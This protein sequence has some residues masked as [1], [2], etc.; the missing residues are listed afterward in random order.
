M[1]GEV[2][3]FTFQAEINQLMSLIINTFYSNKEV[4][5]RELISN[6]SD[7]LDKIRYQSLSDVSVLDSKRELEI[8]IIPNKEAKTLTII[9]SGVGMTKA[10]L[11]KNLGT[12]ANSGTKSFMEQ[13]QSGAAD[14][15]MI[16][17]FGVGFYSAYLVADTVIVHS[18]NNDDEQYVWESSAGGEFT[19]ALD[20]T[21]PLGRGTK[22]V[23]H[24]KEDQ[25]DYLDEQKI[26]NLVKKHSEFIQYPIS[27][28][29][30]KEVEKEVEEPKTEEKTEDE[31]SS[32]KIEEIEEDEEKKDK[33]KV[34]ETTH[35]F[36]I[37]NKTKPIWTKNPN[38]VTKEEYTAFYKSISNDWEEPLA[39]K[40]FS[41]E[42]QLEFKSILFVPK[43]APFDLFESK[44]KHN[45][46]KLYVK[47][48]FIMDNC[49]ELI[50]EYLNFVRGIVDSEDLP[51]NI[52]RE[53]LQ[54][55]KIL[56]VIRKNLVKKCLEMFAEIAENKDDYKKFYEAFAKN[57]KLGIHEDTQ[58]REKLAD[59][60]RYQTSKSGDDFAT[61]KEY[62][63]RMKENQKDIYYITGESKKT[64][65]NS[66]FV[67][68]LKKKSLEV[69][70]M[71]DPIDEYA[72]QQLK[73][74][75]G[76]KLV[77]ITKEGLKLEE[78]EEEKQKAEND[79]KDNEEL[80]KEIKDVLGD[81]VEKVVVSN[82]IVQSPCVLV[83]GEFGWS[84]NM[85]R[86]MKAQALRD[87]SMSTYMTSKKTLEINPDH[88]IIAEL[89][90]RSNEKAKTFK[91]YVYL[92]YETSLLSSGFS[93][94]DPN[95]FTSRIHRMIKLG[96][97]IQDAAE[98]VA[99]SSS[100]DMPPLESSNEASQME[101]VD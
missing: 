85:E 44:K 71:V 47:R 8:K 13:L 6:A 43:R 86:I 82:R 68:A 20:H 14:V 36:E 22:I 24:M 100:E 101:Q 41:V 73:E 75:D 16:G 18:K 95:S 50:P 37:L 40:H 31:S 97:E 80:C 99:T 89:R 7:A 32:A 56:K 88:P 30:T 35:E 94:D 60:L 53:T 61:L 65:E 91:D 83:T 67:E 23:L 84:S 25:L 52:S 2:E 46:I 5:L 26:K 59:L 70:Y 15:S 81:K 33:K 58:N 28:Y 27:L 72:V 38:D 66:P 3:R 4:F 78:T 54:Q 34:K 49:Q 76:K 9:D 87:N 39:H 96:L 11:V 19:V 57:L 55:N 98:E 51:L 12:I 63:A 77:S 17:Q 92:L 93:L 64:V 79:K 90:K 48:V 42:G 10:D 21:E 62:V 29:V 69:I 74:F 45:N 1:S